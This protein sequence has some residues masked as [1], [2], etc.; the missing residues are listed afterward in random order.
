MGTNLMRAHHEWATRPADERF[1]DMPAL[2]AFTKKQVEACGQ[3]V[4]RTR[5][6]QFSANDEG[7]LLLQG[8]GGVPYRMTNWSFAQV[9]GYAGAPAAYLSSLPATLA[10]SCLN[11]GLVRQGTDTDG[12]AKFGLL[13]ATTLK[14]AETLGKDPYIRAL[15][16]PKYARISDY[17]LARIG[18]DLMTEQG[19]T[20]PATRSAQPAGLYASDR[21]VFIFLESKPVGDVVG[22]PGL[23]RFIMLGNSEVGRTSLWM[24]AGY[25]DTICGNHIVWGAK[26]YREI[27]LRHVGNVRGRAEQIFDVV[28]RMSADRGAV[29]TDLARFAEARTQ[30]IAA[31]E[32]EVIGT[33][34]RLLGLPE[35]VVQTAWTIAASTPRY[36]DPRSPWGMVSGLTEA[37][38]IVEVAPTVDARVNIEVAAGNLLDRRW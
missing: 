3:K 6:L 29:Q 25:C 2:L 21:D 22:S 5:E 12:K 1:A 9:C 11:D 8:A 26:D 31:T 35:R 32:E 36:G 33:V 10:A 7:A 15:T 19:W 28:Q 23:T 18:S 14:G 4:V 13:Y 38:Q 17:E 27:R 34:R 37:A 24:L 20:V 16:G 30:R